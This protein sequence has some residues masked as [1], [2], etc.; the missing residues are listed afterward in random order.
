[1]NHPTIEVLNVFASVYLRESVQEVSC[2]NAETSG[3]SASGIKCE[4]EHVGIG[5]ALQRR[6]TAKSFLLLP[7][8]R[9]NRPVSEYQDSA[10]LFL[11]FVN[12]RSCPYEH[13][14]SPTSLQSQN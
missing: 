7:S 13:L 9:A 3:V 1:M 5:F 6:V 11:L 4:A 8:F 10:Q 12:M 14:R 2:A